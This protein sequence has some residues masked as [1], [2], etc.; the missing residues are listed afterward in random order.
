MKRFTLMTILAIA[1]TLPAGCATPV[2]HAQSVS[3]VVATTSGGVEGLERSGSCAFLGIPYAAPPTGALRWKPPQPA[4]AWAPSTLSA[5]VQP[6]SCAQLNTGT[7]LPMGS[8]DCLK[9]NVWTPNP[10]PIFGAP[11]IVWLH[12]G[13]FVN[14]SAN[15]QP[16]N[17]DNL[18]ALTGAIIVAPNYRLGPL[19]FLGHQ[20]L[21]TEGRGTGNYGLLDQ[22]AALEW[23]RDH[24][25]AFGGDPN[26]VTIAGQSAGAH[27]VSLHV[28]S[29]GSA[30][31]F[32]RAI[33]QSGY[34]SY[35]WRTT[36]DAASQGDQFAAALGC[37]DADASL[38]LACLR[39]K[40]SG[41]LLLALPPPL[42]E[43]FNETGRTQWTPVV[44]GV[45]IP[46]QPRYS[47]EQGAFNHVPM[48]LGANRDEGW[49]FVQRSFPSGLSTEQYASAIDTE[50]GQDANAILSA[51]PV[52]TFASPKDALA[53]IAGDA[54]Y[55]CE[56]R[57]VARL[58]ERT[59]TPVFVYSFEHEVD[60]V[61]LDRV[62]H[63]LDVNFVFG[64]NFGPPL[65]P[66]YTLSPTDLSLWRAMSGYWT[67]FAK[68]GNPNIDDSAVVHWPAFTRPSG[69]GRGVDKYLVLD[70]PIHEG[71]RLSE[72]ACDFWEP[73][74][75][76]S[77]TG[78]VP[79]GTP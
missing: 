26:N 78:S 6:L 5:K 66:N 43:Q 36:T 11:V 41:Q 79:A 70:S 19:G 33:M 77:I 21:S 13:G 71:E 25:S 60:A 38:L 42:F 27:S 47:Y 20:A 23:V 61:V 75:L 44:D 8:E 49:T 10:L 30:G 59:K 34:A 73:Y 35:R 57:R 76:R 9:L 72:A 29:P 63:G 40:S 3:C 64:N 39:S 22:R 17:G 51:Y 32:H 24:I 69:A 7:G 67:R 58:I 62:V 56:A 28:V 54:E 65:F 52:D 53:R 48:L 12:P 68:T 14:A 15:F 2:V 46:D 4:A 16:Q 1:S 31:L 50:F 37:T 18:A 74:F 45:E 55:V